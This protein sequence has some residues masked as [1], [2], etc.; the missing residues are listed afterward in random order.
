MKRG[1]FDYLSRESAADLHETELLSVESLTNT[2][3][4]NPNQQSCIIKTKLI[5]ILSPACRCAY[6]YPID[7]LRYVLQSNLSNLRLPSF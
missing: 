3:S 2:S 7:S 6:L 4:K 5:T 1:Y